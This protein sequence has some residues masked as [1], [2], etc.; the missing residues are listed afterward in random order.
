MEVRVPNTTWCGR[1]ADGRFRYRVRHQGGRWGRWWRALA[2]IAARSVNA[3]RRK[4]DK[5]DACRL[6]HADDLAKSLKV[7][8]DAW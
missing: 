6:V 5:S 1:P 7:D 4:G 8:I 3:V 2:I